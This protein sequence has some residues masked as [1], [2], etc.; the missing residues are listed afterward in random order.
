MA[1]FARKLKRRQLVEARKK[2]MKDFK[3]SMSKFKSQVKCSVC[4]RDPR[5]GEKIDDWHINK[6]SEK[7]DLICT[8]CYNESIGEEIDETV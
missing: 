6:Y 8:D 5:D 2:F 4:N 1:S 3:T 7:I